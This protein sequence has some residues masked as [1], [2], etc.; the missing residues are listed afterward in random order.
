MADFFTTASVVDK[1]AVAATLQ[2]NEQ[3]LP[4]A[5]EV[6]KNM[7]ETKEGAKGSNFSMCEIIM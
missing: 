1:A 7:N 5:P 3:N 2:Q 4:A 6:S